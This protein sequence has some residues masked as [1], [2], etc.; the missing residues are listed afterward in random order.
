MKATTRFSILIL[1]FAPFTIS[2]A[3]YTMPSHNAMQRA[4]PPPN[5]PYYHH[6]NYQNNGKE[7]SARY[8]FTVTLKNDSVITTRTRIFLSDSLDDFIVVKQKKVL[9]TLSPGDTKSISRVD[10]YGK[11]WVGI[12]A[13]SCWLFKCGVGEINSYSF[14]A[15]PVMDYVIA[16]QKGNKGPIVPLTKE[17]LELMVGTDDPKIR[18]MILMKNF[19]GAI[20]IYNEK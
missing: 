15:E 10:P 12:P 16:I 7:I 14:V 5:I 20:Q 11:V 3:Q 1:F 6:Y 2:Y 13:D 4:M 19:G 18:Q 17:N 9:K 8:K